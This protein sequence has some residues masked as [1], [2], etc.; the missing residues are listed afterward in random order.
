[1]ERLH[2]KRR[3]SGRESGRP[4]KAAA[5]VKVGGESWRVSDLCLLPNELKWAVSEYLGNF[6]LAM[7]CHTCPP[8]TDFCGDPRV[9]GPRLANVA[10]IQSYFW[11]LVGS[12]NSSDVWWRVTLYFPT[13]ASTDTLRTL[14]TYGPSHNVATLINREAYPVIDLADFRQ[15]ED[16]L[17]TYMG[18]LRSHP[19]D[20]SFVNQPLTWSYVDGIWRARE[21]FYGRMAVTLELH[22]YRVRGYQFIIHT[23]PR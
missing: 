10:D 3:G 14:V 13:Y 4:P 15:L 6:D 22:P 16:N 2:R 12:N 20:A 7:L 8:W 23:R 11:A 17:P 19:F 1:M 18:F 21:L 9:W 5:T